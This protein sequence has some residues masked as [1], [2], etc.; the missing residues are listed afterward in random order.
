MKW[1][2]LFSRGRVCLVTPAELNRLRQLLHHS[3]S[4]L[5]LLPRLPLPAATATA[6][7]AAAGS[8]A[9]PCSP[10]ERPRAPM[11][12]ARGVLNGLDQWRVDSV[13]LGHYALHPGVGSRGFGRKLGNVVL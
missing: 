10:A 4:L 11:T 1:V 6:G 9:R 8:M 5:L 2:G 7:A 12:S 13:G 3:A